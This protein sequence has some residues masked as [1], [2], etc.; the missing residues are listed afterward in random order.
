M[1]EF[2]TTPHTP[3]KTSLVTSP[4]TIREWPYCSMVIDGWGTFVKLTSYERVDMKR[5]YWL[6]LV[7][8]A[9]LALPAPVTALAAAGE[10]IWIGTTTG[11]TRLNRID[12]STVTYT[13]AD[14]LADNRVWTIAIDPAG[15]QW[16]GTYDAGASMFDGQAWH[17]YTT[18]DGLIDNDVK[19]ILFTPDGRTW[20]G[21]GGGISVF[22]GQDWHSYTYSGDGLSSSF[23]SDLAVDTA[24]NVWAAT[25]S[26]GLNRLDSQGWRTYTTGDGL[27]DNFVLDIA[28]DPA[29]GIW[30]AT[31][32]GVSWFDGLAWHSYTT[33]D[34]LVNDTVFAVEITP[35]GH[36]WFGTFDGVSQFDGRQWTTHFTGWKVA[37]LAV[38]PDG[39][40]WAAGSGRVSYFDGAGWTEA[41]SGRFAGQDIRAVAVDPGGQ[42]WVGTFGDGV[43]AFLPGSQAGPAVPVDF[44][45]E[46]QS[47]NRNFPFNLTLLHQEDELKGWHCTTL[48]NGSRTDCL[49]VDSGRYSIT[50]TV[51]CGV[52][53]VQVSSN[54]GGGVGQAILTASGTS[55][56]WRL[57]QPPPGEF[58]IPTEATLVRP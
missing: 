8:L 38:G 26:E 39:R 44:N 41:L 40:L 7:L 37:D 1:C 25:V 42:V 36:K 22:D 9:L 53:R 51:E 50:G 19:A 27:V 23:I 45:G 33:A 24:G 13:T 5:Q 54:Y 2:G 29:G 30:A 34:G 21:T 46:W 14:G 28:A 3:T 55:L 11:V 18:A 4:V 10:S 35:D 32:A 17:T 52:A 31:S 57:V 49:P 15:H 16:A 56:Q 6:F 20:F 48:L 12:G 43:A 47:T 58:Y